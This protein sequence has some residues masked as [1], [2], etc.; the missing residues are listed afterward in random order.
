MDDL[1]TRTDAIKAI[2]KTKETSEIGVSYDGEVAMQTINSLPPADNWTPVNEQLP[3]EY[4]ECF[5]TAYCKL[6]NRRIMRLCYFNGTDWVGIPLGYEV[7]AWMPKPTLYKGD[8]V[9]E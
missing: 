8:E 5:V 9:E 3:N 1:I 6:I 4:E 7:K 2:L